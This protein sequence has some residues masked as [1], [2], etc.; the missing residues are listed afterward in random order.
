MIHRKLKALPKVV[1]WEKKQAGGVLHFDSDVFPEH[2]LEM[3][4]LPCYMH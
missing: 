4:K 1:I 2:W 3:Y